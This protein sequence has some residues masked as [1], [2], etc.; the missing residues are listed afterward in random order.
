VDAS[1]GP[2]SPV[3]A[4]RLRDRGIAAVVA[5]EIETN[6]H[7]SPVTLRSE[8][9]E[10]RRATAADGKNLAVHLPISDLPEIGI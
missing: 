4:S 8:A 6:A 1:A 2:V 7:A 3:A 10:P 9:S 5:S